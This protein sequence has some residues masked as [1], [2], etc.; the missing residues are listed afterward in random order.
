MKKLCKRLLQRGRADFFRLN[1]NGHFGRNRRGETAAMD[2]LTAKDAALEYSRQAEK[3]ILKWFRRDLQVE[4]KS[5]LSPV[6]V[7]DR[8]AEQILRK[9]I[10]ADYPNCGIIGEEFGN[11]NEDAEWV[12][13]LDPI[14]GTRSFVRGLPLFAVLTALLHK[15]KPVLGTLALPA[16]G[17][18]FW[19]V[20]GHGAWCGDERL[21]VS[22]QTDLSRSLVAIADLY[23]FEQEKRKALVRWLEKEA[24]MVR[25]YPD[26]FGHILA[27]RGAVDVMVDPLAKIWDYAPCKIL[28]EEAG[29]EFAN[30]TGNRSSIR[31]GTGLSGNAKLVQKIRKQLAGKG[32]ASKP[33]A[34]TPRKRKRSR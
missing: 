2:L 23:C 21:S 26:A 30:F 20:E 22:P 32:K 16:I 3:E 1:G 27:A 18:T 14:D 8:N 5:D 34:K 25:T 17:E 6:T 9:N 11:E 19:A 33:A 29:G 7:A 28:V 10:N 24:A 13:T 4:A 15:G 12:W 31:E